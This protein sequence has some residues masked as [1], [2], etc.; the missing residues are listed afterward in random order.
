MSP[1]GTPAP[2]KNR[3]IIGILGGLV[4]SVAILLSVGLFGYKW[5]LN[6][7]IN[8]MSADLETARQSLEP[9]TINDLARLNVRLSSTK[10]LISTHVVLSPVFDFLEQNTLQ[11][12]RFSSFSF[13]GGTAPALEMKGLAHGYSSVALESDQF[14]NTMLDKK[15][16]LT[17]VSFSDL[18]LDDKGN[19][20]FSI[21]ANVNPSL[22]SY[23][24][25]YAPTPAAPAAPVTPT[26]AA[27]TAATTTPVTPVTPVAATTTVAAATGTGTMCKAGDYNCIIIASKS[28]TLATMTAV[29]GGASTRYDVLGSTGNLCHSRTIYLGGTAAADKMK[30]TMNDCNSAATDLTGYLTAVQKAAVAGS[31]L[32]DPATQFLA[33]KC[34]LVSS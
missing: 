9:A 10:D 34:K 15:P 13:T 5:Y 25:E 8:K 33:N 18:N 14:N 2:I 29:S 1:L 23:S 11:S 7:Q 22:I 21:T 31:S 24:R 6:N 4:F 26:P 20:V 19:V 30:G 32:S 17:A 27:V 28:C 16:A 12:V 3:S